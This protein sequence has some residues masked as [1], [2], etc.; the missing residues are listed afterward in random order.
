MADKYRRRLYAI[1]DD[2][3]FVDL[4]TK[5]KLAERLNIKPETV[6]WLASPSARKRYKKGRTSVFIGFEDEFE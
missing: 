2:D 4:G 5:E 3:N 6:S 1:Y